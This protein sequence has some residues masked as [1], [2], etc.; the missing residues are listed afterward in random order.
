MALICANK[1]DRKSYMNEIDGFLVL[2]NFPNRR[3]TETENEGN[4]TIFALSQAVALI[5]T[6]QILTRLLAALLNFA[7]RALPGK[8]MQ[9]RVSGKIRNAVHPPIETCKPSHL[10]E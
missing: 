4:F 1:S 3:Q 8:K 7:A 10:K 2:L 6:D 5:K 9:L